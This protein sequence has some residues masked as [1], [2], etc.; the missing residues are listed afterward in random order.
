MTLGMII[1]NVVEINEMFSIKEFILRT[2][3]LLQLRKG[4]KRELNHL[5]WLNI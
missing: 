4:Y 5:K 3:F 1:M 2:K